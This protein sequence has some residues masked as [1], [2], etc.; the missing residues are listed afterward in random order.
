[1]AQS[2][3][4]TEILMKLAIVQIVLGVLVIASLVCTSPCPH[5]LFGAGVLGVGMAQ[6]VKARK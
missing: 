5:V 6:L 1:M 4:R 3:L 2:K